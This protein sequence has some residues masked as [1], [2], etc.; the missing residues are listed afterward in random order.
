MG[1]SPRIGG[2]ILKSPWRAWLWRWVVRLS[3]GLLV[4]LG[5]VVVTTGVIMRTAWGTR[6]ALNIGLSRYNAMISGAIE[7]G[8]LSGSLAHGV[9]LEDIE[10]RDGEEHRLASA[11]ALCFGV[12]L[13]PLLG[14]SLPVDTIAITSA[15]VWLDAQADWADLGPTRS[16]ADTEAAPALGPPGPDL[17][18]H[19]VVPLAIEDFTLLQ[20][21]PDR[22]ATAIVSHVG[23][24]GRVEAQGTEASVSINELVGDVAAVQGSVTYGNIEAKWASPVATL[25]RLTVASSLGVV[26]LHAG[27]VDVVEQTYRIRGRANLWQVPGN[28]PLWAVAG[29]EGRGTWASARVEVDAYAPTVGYVGV[30]AGARFDTTPVVTAMVTGRVPQA[31]EPLFATA[32]ARW[33]D[34]P[35]ASVVAWT[36]PLRAFVTMDGGRFQAQA[37]LPG[38]AVGAQGQLEGWRPTSVEASVKV[39][40]GHQTSSALARLTGAEVATLEGSGRVHARCT[41]APE[42]PACAVDAR[43]KHPQANLELEGGVRTGERLTVRL[44]RLKGDVATLP[45]VLARP[46]TLTI[47]PD[48][49]SISPLRMQVLGGVV[50]ASGHV[51]LEAGASRSSDLKLA[52]ESIQLDPLATWIPQVPIRGT[53]NAQASIRGR[54]GDPNVQLEA[55]VAR[56]RWQDHRL[57]RL[58]VQTRVQNRQWVA[59]L[60]WKVLGSRVMASLD[61]PLKIRPEPFA[62]SLA[63]QAPLNGHVRM[64]RFALKRLQPWLPERFEPSGYATAAI[65]VTGVAAQP[66]VD[67]ELAVDDVVVQKTRWGRARVRGQLHD[68][69]AQVAVQ[70]DGKP[71]QVDAEIKTPLKVNMAQPDVQWSASAIEADVEVHKLNL[72]SWRALADDPS[73]EGRIYAKVHAEHDAAGLRGFGGVT[74]SRGVIRGYSIGDLELDLGLT[75]SW[76]STQARLDGGQLGGIDLTGQI[77][78][79]ASAGQFKVPMLATARPIFVDLQ[80]DTMDLERVQRWGRPRLSGRAGGRVM[81]EGT[82]AEP[83]LEAQVMLDELVARDESLGRVGAEV[84]YRDGGLKTRLTQRGGRRRMDLEA[85]VPVTIRPLEG[86]VAWRRDDPHRLRASVVGFDRAVLAAF[87]DPPIDWDFVSHADLKVDGTIDSLVTHAR[88]QADVRPGRGRSVPIWVAL[89]ASSTQQHLEAFVGGGGPQGLVASVDTE[90]D[91]VAGLDG[92]LDVGGVPVTVKVQATDVPLHGINPLL[93]TALHDAQGTLQLRAMATGTLGAPVMSGELELSEGAMTVVALNQRFREIDVH[94][95]F[96]RDTL[97]LSSLRARSGEGTLTGQGTLHFVPGDVYGQLKIAARKLPIVRQGLPPMR[98]NSTIGVELDARG[99]LTEIDVAIADGFVDV[100]KTEVSA[101]PKVLPSMDDVVFVDESASEQGPNGEAPWLPAAM[102]IAVDLT[103]PVRIRGPQVDM[104]WEGG[105]RVHRTAAGET[106]TEGQFRAKTGW[107]ALFSNDFELVEGQVELPATG[108]VDPYVNVR[109][110]TE[111]PDASVTMLVR[112]R[113]SRPE[114]ILQSDPSM[115]QTD[116]FSL[117]ITGRAD[118]TQADEQSFEAKAASLLAAFQNSALQRY[119]RDRIGVDRVGVSFGD[120]VEQP[121]VTVGKRINRNVYV[122]SEYHHAAPEDENQAEVRLEYSFYR[123]WT[124]ETFFGDR[125]VGEI[126]VWWTKAFEAGRAAK[127]AQQ[128]RSQRQEK[129]SKDRPTDAK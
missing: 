53:V 90:V 2:R 52:L 101:A 20:A 24:R 56:L 73:L 125:T 65:D 99:E 106:H 74:A 75:S 41:L 4:V 34:E 91:L 70:V 96:A 117:L 31:R 16:E 57:G 22:E 38:T 94:G 87:I 126:G 55:T 9:C 119:L 3:M 59:S 97:E 40:S 1:D 43:V 108:D 27:R 72:A 77:P 37:R 95:T 60:D 64:S 25:D 100:I 45:M 118:T 80:L 49:L 50:Q 54:L 121:I 17:P 79:E 129:R 32:H 98:L 92:T 51:G 86:D 78:L 44:D 123:N 35:T 13:W 36:T 111:T 104:Q 88:V 63:R 21:Q 114:L 102:K 110:T 62:V 14:R 76:L 124:L 85:E 7:V 67:V 127:T 46:A 82:L 58:A 83:E 68:N 89:D 128:R 105:V 116:I 12:R 8:A 93:P 15:T 39:A 71:I 66:D 81:L 69:V 107:V 109:A 48:Q 30:I 6:V 103:E 11:G 115:P 47:S 84:H 61:V 112:G 26:D 5:L 28:T 113:V 23:L 29:F 42:A 18:L 120:T 19:L 122:E 10:L 33:D